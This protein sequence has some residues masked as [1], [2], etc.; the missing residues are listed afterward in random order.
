[1]SGQEKGEK[2]GKGGKKSK[3]EERR[4]RQAKKQL[5]GSTGP[6]NLFCHKPETIS[7]L[8]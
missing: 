3:E 4:R 6:E 2:E 7:R 1:M 5:E 8:P